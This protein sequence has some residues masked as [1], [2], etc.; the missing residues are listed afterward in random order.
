[1]DPITNTTNTKTNDTTTITSEPVTDTTT[2]AVPGSKAHAK[3]IADAAAALVAAKK[4]TTTTTESTTISS[5]SS[6]PSDTTNKKK[7]SRLASLLAKAMGNNNIN[8]SENTTTATTTTDTATTT[9]STN[10]VVIPTPKL[11]E[12]PILLSKKSSLK[13]KET[14]ITEQGQQLFST[15]G[16]KYKPL[17]RLLPLNNNFITLRLHDNQLNECVPLQKSTHILEYT[18]P[19]FIP[20][21]VSKL[22]IDNTKDG[23]MH[24]M[25]VENSKMNITNTITNLNITG[26]FGQFEN[27]IN[28]VVGQDIG[29]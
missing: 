21:E 7:N 4:G 23:I 17:I 2:P 5:T 14:V 10:A 13:E 6:S 1:M 8:D 18:V 15:Y 16:A 22:F 28:N 25:L 24:D 26:L 9:P 20:S 27:I 3:S 12:N 29:I 11:K 19:S